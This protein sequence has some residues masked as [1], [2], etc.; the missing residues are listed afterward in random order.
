MHFH[1]Q[2][3]WSLLARLPPSIAYIEF[4]GSDDVSMD[5]GYVLH[6]IR[7]SERIGHKVFS[8]WVKVA[9][10]SSLLV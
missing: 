6:T 4:L 5:I 3:V 1:F 10:I 9:D 2:L 7:W 8:L